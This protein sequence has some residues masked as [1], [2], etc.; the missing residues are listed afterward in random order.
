MKKP[1]FILKI[2]RNNTAKVYINGKWQK[3]ITEIN[4]HGVPFSFDIETVR[5]KTD[6]NGKIIVE[7]D[8]VVKETVGYHIGV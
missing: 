7:N 1:K 5:N 4:I 3:Q 8:E 2:N 6:K